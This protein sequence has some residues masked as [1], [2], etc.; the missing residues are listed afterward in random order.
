MSG[1]RRGGKASSSSQRPKSLS[2]VSTQSTTALLITIASS[3]NPDWM[4]PVL[5]RRRRMDGWMDG[6]T[7]GCS[8]SDRGGGKS[9]STQRK[10]IS[11]LTLHLARS[12]LCFLFFVSLRVEERRRF[13]Q[14]DVFQHKKPRLANTGKNYRTCNR[15]NDT[16]KTAEKR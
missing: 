11:L 14:V 13:H 1:T 7:D 8:S 4:I 9:G 3:S 16:W 12:F 5:K 2:L 10:I 15:P 6:C